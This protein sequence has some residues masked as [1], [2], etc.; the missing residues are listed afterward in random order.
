[1]IVNRRVSVENTLT[2][3]EPESTTA[4]SPALAGGPK[5]AAKALDCSGID[6]VLGEAR[7]RSAVQHDQHALGLSPVP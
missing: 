4:I 1:M 2:T 7:K 6:L 5:I 3:A